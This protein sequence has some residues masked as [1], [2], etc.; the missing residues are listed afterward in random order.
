MYEVLRGWEWNLGAM[1]EDVGSGV[2]VLEDPRRS[3][4]SKQDAAALREDLLRS[5]TREADSISPPT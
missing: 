5:G 2:L 1:F 4:I 3:E